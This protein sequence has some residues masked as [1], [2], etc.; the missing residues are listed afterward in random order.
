[1]DV[2]VYVS[3]CVRACVR[4]HAFTRSTDICEFPLC[5]VPGTMKRNRVLDLASLAG[6]ADNK[7]INK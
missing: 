4:A 3:V 6:D 1:M 2:S 7:Q 5:A